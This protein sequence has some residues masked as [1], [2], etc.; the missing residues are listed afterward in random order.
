MSARMYVIG[1]NSAQPAQLSRRRAVV[2]QGKMQPYE[3][4]IYSFPANRNMNNEILLK[5]NNR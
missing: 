5:L 2:R 3:R 4:R 1:T